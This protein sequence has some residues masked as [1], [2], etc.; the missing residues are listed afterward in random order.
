MPVQTPHPDY[1]AALPIWRT[2]E[3]CIEGEHAVK[4]GGAKFLPMLAGQNESDE[5]RAAYAAYLARA[6][7]F[8][9]TGRTHEAMM[10]FLFRKPPTD[11]LPTSLD[12]FK[13][14]ADLAG[15]PLFSY[16]RQVT[17]AVCG[18]G[19]CGTLIDF[20]AED[21]ENR[22]YF[23]FYPGTSI[24][25]WE[26]ARIKGRMQLIKLVLMDAAYVAKP[27]DEFEKELVIS[28]RV[29]RLVD[30]R[31]SCEIWQTPRS[32]A[33]VTTTSPG[34][35][36]APS[37]PVMVP[38][39]TTQYT[40]RGVPLDF[41]P[42]IFHNADKP[43]EKIGRSPMEDIA[44]INLSHFRTSA[45]LENARHVCGVPTPW[46]KCFGSEANPNPELA[47][48]ASFAWVTDNPDADCG[49]LEFNGQ[50]VSCL[51]KAAEEK[52]T[53][54]AA[55]GA[56]L[57]EPKGGD[58]KAYDTV[59]LEASAETSTLA[60][61]GGQISETLSRACQIADWWLGT[62]T[63]LDPKIKYSLNTDF[64]SASITPEMLTAMVATLQAG[65]ISKETFF[66]QMERG[67]LYKPGW[68][69]EDEQDSIDA[70][71]ALPPPL[72]LDPN[73]PPPTNEPPAPGSGKKPPVKKAA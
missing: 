65:H 22:P 71:P 44:N 17:E 8:N 1:V 43:G 57:I 50:G 19:R 31:A 72:P 45:D 21:G 70:N 69:F 55:V 68:T 34:T 52:Q 63:V 49:F 3:T 37:D 25:N 9:A 30:G 7:F 59:A 33:V 54:M 66:H 12:D 20:S 47:L 53:Q 16:A 11:E 26:V 2:V 61:I 48:G 56:R 13:A 6:C 10:G 4:A 27:T 40:R 67:E 51:E 29:L 64:T 60:R 14:D 38:E 23:S 36:P 58:A 28:Y 32:P 42:F 18:T 39:L 35:G 41:I 15:G 46:A 73:K 24:L 62:A 5:G